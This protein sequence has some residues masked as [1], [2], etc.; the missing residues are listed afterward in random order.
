MS[1]NSR[2]AGVVC[3][4]VQAPSLQHLRCAHV[5]NVD[6]LASCHVQL[7]VAQQQQQQQQQ[8]SV[9]LASPS[10]SVSSPGAAYIIP[11]SAA[12]T[13]SAPA[14]PEAS[15][16]A[17]TPASSAATLA[18]QTA[19]IRANNEI[20]YLKDMVRLFVEPCPVSDCTC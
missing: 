3:G 6:C 11:P 16:S 9:V 19:V 5:I 20:A 1:F 7:S 14:F 8:Q 12:T 13:F 2:C 17:R 10:I 15:P 4:G 18:A